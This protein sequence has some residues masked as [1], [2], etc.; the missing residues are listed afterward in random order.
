MWL[1]G[2]QFVH[3]YRQE[4][5]CHVGRTWQRRPGFTSSR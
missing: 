1:K 4:T 5:L 3:S 2:G